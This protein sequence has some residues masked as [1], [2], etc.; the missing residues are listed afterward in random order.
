MYQPRH[1]EDYLPIDNESDSTSDSDT[2]SLFD[3][4][5]EADTAS[6]TDLD[7]PLEKV[8]SNTDNND[9]LFDDKV[10]HLSEY[11]LAALAN[12]D[13]G[14]LWQKRYSSKIQG[15]LD[16]VKDHHNQYEPNV[17]QLC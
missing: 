14:R 5:N 12:L 9:D 7:S 3:S 2:D 16:W 4:D 6:D 1:D 15:C 10:Q 8:N 11:Y 17:D 13:V